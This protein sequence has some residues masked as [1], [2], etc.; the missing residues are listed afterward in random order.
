MQ[1]IAYRDVIWLIRIKC[2][3]EFCIKISRPCTGFAIGLWRA[4]GRPRVIA[5]EMNIYIY[6][7]SIERQLLYAVSQDVS[8]KTAKYI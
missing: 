4:C 1:K 8:D 5:L 2:A 6:S 3:Y 7:G